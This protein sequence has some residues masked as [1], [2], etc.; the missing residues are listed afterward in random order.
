M[1]KLKKMQ[2]ITTQKFIRTSPRKLRLVAREIVGLKP[3]EA[4]EI[5]PHLGKRAA[6][7]LLKAIKTA[8]ANAKAKGANE[9][10]LVFKEIQINEGPRLKRGRAVARGRWHPIVKRMSHIRVVVE[11][12]EPKAIS[13]ARKKIE[14]KKEKNKQK[15]G[16]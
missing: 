15:K 10:E 14:A 12:K 8:I 9:A 11:T 7:P 3:I 16:K 4:V 13:Q 5:L 2:A 6:E 1:R